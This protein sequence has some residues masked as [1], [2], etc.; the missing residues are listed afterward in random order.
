MNFESLSRTI[1][2]SSTSFI[3]LVEITSVLISAWRFNGFSQKYHLYF[4]YR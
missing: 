4:V 3:A 2:I 1:I